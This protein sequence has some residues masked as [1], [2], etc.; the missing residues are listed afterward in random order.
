MNWR[1]GF[2]DIHITIEDEI[3]EGD[4]VLSRWTLRGTH[5]G[6]FAGTAPTG[7]HVTVTAMTLFRFEAGKIVEGWDYWDALGFMTQLGLLPVKK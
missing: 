3:A 7:K 4:K 6:E 2:P 1:S 5:K